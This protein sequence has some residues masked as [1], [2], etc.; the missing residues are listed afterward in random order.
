MNRYLV[1][2]GAD[3]YPIGGFD[4]FVAGFRELQ[5]AM[6]FI[7]TIHETGK[8]KEP[9][10]WCHIIDTHLM[11]VLVRFERE[12]NFADGKVEWPKWSEVSED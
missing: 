5:Y 7:E 2:A 8:N 10:E 1:F 9:A 3:Y 12:C 6:K 4:D 11:E